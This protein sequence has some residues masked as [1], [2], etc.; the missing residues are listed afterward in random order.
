[1]KSL[2]TALCVGGFLC[3][4]AQ[5]TTG[6]VVPVLVPPR[7]HGTDG[8]EVIADSGEGLRARVIYGPMAVRGAFQEALMNAI[9]SLQLISTCKPS[10]KVQ[11][12]KLPTRCNNGIS[13]EMTAARSLISRL[14]IAQ[15]AIP[16]EVDLTSWQITDSTF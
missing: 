6:T 10:R 12:A 13:G 14:N 4:A 11:E 7:L 16:L 1:M 3:A 8:D 5:V 9:R 2:I 15:L